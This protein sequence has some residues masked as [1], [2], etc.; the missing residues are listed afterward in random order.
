MDLPVTAATTVSSNVRPAPELTVVIPTYNESANVPLL[1]ERLRKTLD[2]IDWEALF[3]DDNSRD[4]TA[5]QARASRVC[6]R[7]RRASSQ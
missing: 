3:V 2:G 7:A 6:W 4:G 5:F 1:V